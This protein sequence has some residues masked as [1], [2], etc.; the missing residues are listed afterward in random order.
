MHFARSRAAR[1]A[2]NRSYRIEASTRLSSTSYHILYLYILSIDAVASI[3]ERRVPFTRALRL[4]HFSVTPV[5]F[6]PITSR[7]LPPLSSH[8]RILGAIP[9]GDLAIAIQFTNFYTANHFFPQIEFS[10]FSNRRLDFTIQLPYDNGWK[11]TRF[12]QDRKSTNFSHFQS[13]ISIIELL[14]IF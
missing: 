6:F 7:Q 11:R 4:Q 8:F 13:F 2:R 14:I 5:P 12:C 9:S 1:A 10:R 3:I